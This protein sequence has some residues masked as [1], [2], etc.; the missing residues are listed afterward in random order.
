MCGRVLKTCV[1]FYV[2]RIWYMSIVA[3]YL[4]RSMMVP[5]QDQAGMAIDVCIFAF[6]EEMEHGIAF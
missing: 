1:K 5:F 4:F 6:F 3:G 2:R